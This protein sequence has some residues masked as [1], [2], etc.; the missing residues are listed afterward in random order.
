MYKILNTLK[1]FWFTVDS[2]GILNEGVQLFFHD[3]C[4]FLF[5][6]LIVNLAGISSPPC[7]KSFEHFLPSPS[8]QD[9]VNWIDEGINYSKNHPDLIEIHFA[10][11]EL[12]EMT[13]AK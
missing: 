9:I 6:L 12:Q 5:V 8:K 3:I 7:Y 1:L 10:F 13:Q 4:H 2:S 11:V